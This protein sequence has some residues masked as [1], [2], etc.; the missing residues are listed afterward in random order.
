[1]KT[2]T[3]CPTQFTGMGE[4][5]DP[6]RRR[7]E[8]HGHSADDPLAAALRG[9]GFVGSPEND[10]IDIDGI[11]SCRLCER[12][13]RALTGAERARRHRARAVASDE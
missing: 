10:I 3:D 6:C 2:C 1:M 5:C 11:P 7:F 8:K 4:R 9:A 12:P 13:M